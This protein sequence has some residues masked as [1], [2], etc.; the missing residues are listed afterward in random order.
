[1]PP[2]AIELESVS[3][4]YVLGE[5]HGREDTLRDAISSSVR[6]L[7]G[8]VPAP[9]EI[10]P[11]RDVSLEVE[12][13]EALGIVGRNGA[14]KSTLLKVVT[15]ITEPTSGV[16]RT[17]GRVGA[18]LEVGTGFHPELTGRENVYLNG[19]I[20]GMPRRE[21]RRRF[22]EIAEFA[23]VAR[24]LDTPVKR[25]SSGMYLRLA[26]AVAAH[27]DAQVMVVD[28]VLAVGDAEFQRK[29]LGKMS[30][31]EREGRTVLFVSHNLDAIAQL[32][33]KSA[34]LDA[35]Q[36][37]AYGPTA[38]VVSAYLT[39]VLR[40][41]EQRTFEASDE[42]PVWLRS[43]SVL[44][45]DGQLSAELPRDRPFEIEL[46]FSVR[47]R[48]PGLDLTVFIQTL[49][50]VWALNEAWSESEAGDRGTPGEYVARIAIP[51][52]LGVGD[53]LAGVWM[54]SPYETFV[55]EV[56]ALRF[57]LEGHAKPGVHRL[58]QLGLRWRV[59][60]AGSAADAAADPLEMVRE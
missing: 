48:V 29:C 41:A 25:Y 10:W 36:V 50:G 54:G 16:S 49:Q 31:I 39:E 33:A 30:S 14:G 37:R 3:K 38:E 44:A 8:P 2:P 32:C 59:C 1:M 56:D 19:A 26:F 46:R 4:R 12:Q 15:R 35:G 27:L 34:W 21:V 60:H 5:H 45:S 58:L 23:G 42:A 28:E 9:Q 24:F 52:V 40:P 17:R 18:L 7:F 22:D 51:P 6:G 57:R 53:Y 43:A 47:E 20:L 55:Y 11:L 13:G